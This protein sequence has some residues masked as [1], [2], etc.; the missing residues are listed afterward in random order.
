MNSIY[1]LPDRIFK[2]QLKIA[3]KMSKISRPIHETNGL[4]VYKEDRARFDQLERRRNRVIEI[5]KEY[6]NGT[7]RNKEESR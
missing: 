4:F 2:L 7:R 3:I 1:S 6:L 5:G